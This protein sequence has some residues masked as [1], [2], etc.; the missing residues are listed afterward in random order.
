MSSNLLHEFSS[1]VRVQRDKCF[2]VQVGRQAIADYV[3][4]EAAARGWSYG[5]IVRRSG[6]HI[7]SAS[8]LVNIVNAN[9]QKVSEDTLRGLARAFEAQPEDLFSIYYGGKPQ[10]APEAFDS[11]IFVMFKGFEELSDEDKAEL[12]A[13]VRMLG[14]EIQRR[15]PQGKK[16]G[17]KGKKNS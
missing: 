2:V 16:G 4:R 7:K 15:R 8:T 12:L 3:T 14:A 5:E 6:G 17:G 13:T 1:Q 9:V 10:P 11:E